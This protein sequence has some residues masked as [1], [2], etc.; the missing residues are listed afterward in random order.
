MS[1]L[2]GPCTAMLCIWSVDER[3][4]HLEAELLGLLAQP[5]AAIVVAADPAEIV[6]AEPEQRAVVDHAAML[7]AHGGIDDLADAELLHVAGQRVLQQ[8]LGVRAGHLELAQR[9]QVHDHRASRGRPSIP[10]SAR[11]WRSALA[12]Q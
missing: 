3:T 2:F 8:R 10:R 6:L 7:V 11:P 9:R 4:Q 5:D 12:S 1:R